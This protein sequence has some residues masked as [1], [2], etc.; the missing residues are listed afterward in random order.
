MT[1][2]AHSLVSRSKA[3]CVNVEWRPGPATPPERLETTRYGDVRFR[4]ETE[5]AIRRL[6]EGWGIAFDGRSRS[7]VGRGYQASVYPDAIWIEGTPSKAM[8][9]VRHSVSALLGPS[10]QSP[11]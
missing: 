1:R 9:E 10:G 8:R 4:S 3:R 2:A 5:S 7:G 11:P 6:L